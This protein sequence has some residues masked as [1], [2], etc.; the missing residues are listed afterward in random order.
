MSK[1]NYLLIIIIIGF[2]AIPAV[3]LA[4]DAANLIKDPLGNA[5]IPVLIGRVIKA[6]LGIVGSIALLMFIWGGFL[7]MTAAGEAKKVEKG[8]QTLIWATIGLATI[9][10]AYA[11]VSFVIKSIGPGEGSAPV[12]EAGEEGALACDCVMEIEECVRLNPENV[13]ECQPDGWVSRPQRTRVS[14]S[15]Q[16]DISNRCMDLC[17]ENVRERGDRRCMGMRLAPET[18][19]TQ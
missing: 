6:V 19:S 3:V 12:S 7:W 5:S 11:A 9:F 14:G 8:K 17:D 15:D 4:A 10:F 18:C 1:K 16:D 13:Y 2:L